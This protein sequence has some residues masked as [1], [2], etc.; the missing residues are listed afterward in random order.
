MECFKR[1]IYLMRHGSAG[2]GVKSDFDRKLTAVGQ[3]EVRHQVDRFQ[4]PDG[5]RPDCIFCSTATRTR[6]TAA[7][8]SHLFQG[9]P[10]YFRETLYLAPTYRI[11]DLVRAI[12]DIFYRPLIIGHN[13]GLEQMADLLN[14]K[15]AH[16]TLFPADCVSLSLSVPTWASVRPGSGQ[17]QQIFS[18]KIT[19]ETDQAVLEQGKR[20]IHD[21]QEKAKKSICSGRKRV[22][23]GAKTAG[24]NYPKD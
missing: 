5:I 14:H 2:F 11:M 3:A 13:P 8:L 21:C 22:S 4:Q 9:I 1:H 17:I 18:G 15:P 16:I 10:V 20:G 6:Q 24:T 23:A 19:C 12:D 7:I